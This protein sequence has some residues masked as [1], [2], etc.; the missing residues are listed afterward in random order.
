MKALIK[1][2]EKKYPGRVESLFSSI[3]NVVPSHLMDT[4]QFDFKDLSQDE[5]SSDLAEQNAWQPIQ[6]IP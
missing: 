3:Q 2:W 6:M 5:A 1:E 4:A